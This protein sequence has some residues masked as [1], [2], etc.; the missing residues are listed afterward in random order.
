MTHET[1]KAVA[2]RLHDSRFATRYL[3]GN[4]IDIG[5]GDDPL[6]DYAALF[7]L[8]K[9]VRAWDKGDGD[10]QTLPGLDANAFD[11]VLSSHCL[12]HLAHPVSA[13][14]RWIGVC[15]PRGHLIITVPDEDLYEHG[16]WPSQFNGEHKWSFNLNKDV[17]DVRPHSLNLLEIL[18][19]FRYRVEILSV[20]LLDAGYDPRRLAA[21]DQSLLVPCEPAIEVVLRKR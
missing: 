14:R 10:A 5:S 12:E 6:T 7:P 15:K 20:H 8:I 4:G 3:V 11:F 18:I 1:G 17:D 13:L 16:L 21:F 2:R 9:N 19:G